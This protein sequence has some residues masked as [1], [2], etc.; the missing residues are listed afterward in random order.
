MRQFQGRGD[1][2]VYCGAVFAESTRVV[3]LA[4]FFGIPELSWLYL[5]LRII[6]RKE[7]DE[8]QGRGKDVHPDRVQVAGPSSFN[9]FGRQESWLE[10]QVLKGAEEFTVEMGD[11]VK[12]MGDQSPNGF[13]WLGVFLSADVAIT[14]IEPGDYN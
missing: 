2:R 10:Y 5:C 1:G 13:F 9:V 14:A 6:Y 11:V 12:K 3:S 8:E 4:P 7:N